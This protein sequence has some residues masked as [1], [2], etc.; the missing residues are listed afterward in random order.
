MLHLE[1]PVTTAPSQLP[2]IVSAG[3][4]L[5][6]YERDEIYSQTGARRRFLWLELEE[7]VRD[8][9]DEYFI[10]LLG[11]AP[12][13]LLTDN[14]FETFVPPE[15]A[16]LPIDPELVRVITPGQTD[17]E[18]GR[19][20][21]VEL[22]PAG[23]SD[24]HF[25]VPLPPG[26]NADD[27]E[28]FG[29]FTYELRAGHA[30]IW[31]TAQGRFGRALRSTGVQHPAPTLFCAAQ[32]NEQELVVEAPY[33]EV[34]LNGKNITANPPRTEIWALLYAQVRQADGKDYRNVL[35][36]DRRLR[37]LPRVRGRFKDPNGNVLIPFQNRDAV[38]HGAARWTQPEILQALHDLG[39][40]GDAPLSVLCVEMIAALRTPATS[41]LSG[42]SL[43]ARTPATSPQSSVSLGLAAAVH[44]ER[45]GTGATTATAASDDG[46][47]P[48]SEALG[49][50]RIL[51]TSPLAPVPEVCCPSC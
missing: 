3:I 26:L 10:R 1:L 5:S 23:N 8:P 4:A 51:R 43:L 33:A 48:L 42:V 39:L 24:R 19:A 2:R 44:A 20:A 47:R 13:P 22:Q 30:H 25:L 40:P 14:R 7:P 21:M 49:H 11:Y 17:D 32:R 34:V 46:L 38:A 29:F 12:D 6:K 28:L 15:E 37:I 27:P 45:A 50:F 16:P 41:T 31:S 18:A 35:L 9:N 36:D